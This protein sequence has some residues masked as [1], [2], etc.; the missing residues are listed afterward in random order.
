MTQNLEH[1]A[2][3]HHQNAHHVIVIACVSY[4]LQDV[5]NPPPA[6]LLQRGLFV[7]LQYLHSASGVVICQYL[8]CAGFP[9]LQWQRAARNGDGGK[10]LKLFAW[11]LHVY[12]S[13]CHKPVAAQIA[14]IAILNF[15]CVL[16]ALQLVLAATCSLSLLGRPS[17]NMYIDRLLETINKIQQGW[18]RSASAAS[19]GRALDMTTLLRVLLHVRHAFQATEHGVT[20]TDDPVTDSMLVQARLLQD[21]FRRILG[22]DL[23]IYDPL[24]WFWHTGN[25]VQL[26]VGD[27]RTY[28]PWLWPRATAEGRSAGKGRVRIERWDMYVRRFVFDHIFQF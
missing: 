3:G 7:Y 20:E 10:L 19:F 9:T 25:A 2:Y 13:A 18:K 1:N 4:L 5:T 21:E 26:D 22:T 14:L 8:R 28:R 24:N 27:F 11:S 16:P 17:S 23:T 6:L 15:T 12:R